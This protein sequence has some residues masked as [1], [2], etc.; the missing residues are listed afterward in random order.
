[1]WV[2]PQTVF[3]IHKLPV[4][5]AVPVEPVST[6]ADMKTQST[7]TDAG[8]DFSGVWTINS[9]VNN[10]YPILRNPSN[11]PQNLVANTGNRQVM[12][13]WN[14]NAETNFLKYRIYM[15]STSNGE[16]LYDSTSNGITDTTRQIN[17]LVNGS[18]YY[19]KVT[20]IGNTRQ[21]SGLSNEASAS[22]PVLPFPDIS[23]SSGILPGG[24]LGFSW[25]DF[26]GDGY[27]DLFQS[28]GNASSY[29]YK[30][31][32]NGTFTQVPSPDSSNSNN[33]NGSV[34]AD[35]NGDGKLDLL[36]TDGYGSGVSSLKMVSETEMEDSQITRSHQVSLHLLRKVALRILVALLPLPQ[37]PILI[38]MVISKSFLL[39]ITVG[40]D[41]GIYIF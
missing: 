23:L 6:T 40:Q 26:N 1:M 7:F 32:G 34:W 29:L 41:H 3:G 10:G 16:S 21:E 35:F 20:A 4:K 15:S 22:L 37:L 33:T 17:G 38:E 19:F 2:P 24:Q 39:V 12:L 30:N 9:N 36:F 5:Q 11:A 25:G 31:N 27:L 14:K 28:A 13:M 18:T 8:W